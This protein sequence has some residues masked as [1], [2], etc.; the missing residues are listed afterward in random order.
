MEIVIP[1]FTQD[2]R[3]RKGLT[4]SPET[5]RLRNDKELENLLRLPKKPWDSPPKIKGDSLP[6]TRG[7]SPPKIWG[8]SGMTRNN[9]NYNPKFCEAL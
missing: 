4:L 6:K 1:H 7:D 3:K 2:R 8:D 5:G 9:P